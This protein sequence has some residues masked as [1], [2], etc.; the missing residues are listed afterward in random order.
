V[1]CKGENIAIATEVATSAVAVAAA[2]AGNNLHTGA[3]V[4]RP[5]P[6]M[7]KFGCLCAGS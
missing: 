5:M 6:Q 1:A 4:G 3:A 2:A 7:S